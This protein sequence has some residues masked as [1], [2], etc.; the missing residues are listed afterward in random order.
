[1]HML[2]QRLQLLVSPEQRRRLEARAKETGKSV[3][4][5]I[6]EAIDA[7]YGS[8]SPEDRIRAAREIAEA[9]GGRFLTIA[10]MDQII[11]DERTT[12]VPALRRGRRRRK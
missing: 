9:R 2:D 11:S 7:R 4:Q 5:L 1:M 12:N 8:V 10:Q 6:R 3:G